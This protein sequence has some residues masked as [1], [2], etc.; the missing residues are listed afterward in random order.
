MKI[1]I[2]NG[3]VV[4]PVNKL[5]GEYDILIEDGKI[6]SVAKGI[7]AAGAEVS[8]AAG[9]IVAPGLID[10][11]TH[12]REPGREDEE[13][14]LS[15]SRA[16]VKGGFTAVCAMPNTTPPCDNQ[17]VVGFIVGEGKRIGL[18]NIYV[19][20]AITKGRKGEELS[21]M[22]ELHDAGVVALSDDGDSVDNSEIMRLA[23]EYASMLKLTVI[24]HCEDKQLSR[25]GVMNESFISTLLGLKGR[26]AVSEYTRIS[27]DIELCGMTRGKLHVAHVSA[28]R[29]VE[30]IRDAKKRGINV[31]AETCPHY[32]TLTDEAVKTSGFDT[33]MKMN[34]PLRTAD[35]RDAIRAGIKD[36]TI[37]CIATDHA[38]HTEDEKDREFD[39]APFGII[40]L[41]TA[42][43]LAIME[44]IDTKTLTWSELIERMSSNP[45]RILG[46][47]KG[48][49]TV[50]A[51]ADIV[52]IDHQKKWLVTKEALESKSKNTPFLGKT[53]KGIAVMTITG[54]RV[55]YREG[56]PK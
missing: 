33:N 46:L 28:R 9:K 50:G 31:T 17:G 27:R 23:L 1:L 13:T 18:C 19:I 41:E 2:K 32:F 21:E 56:A 44:L 5:D 14:L 8:D 11:H 3:H 37:D 4:D 53:L 15:A 54:G 29:S 12:L 49:L 43:S 6:S 47:N 22:G 36:G 38:P 25:D 26:P 45:A 34:P 55:T 40:G 16:A 24:G 52:I 20:G 51:D 35:D 39:A 42:L 30:L 7:K 48:N 10:M